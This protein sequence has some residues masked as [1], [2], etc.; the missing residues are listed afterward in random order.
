MQIFP[1]NLGK[2]GSPCQGSWVLL[3]P[4]NAFLLILRKYLMMRLK[5]GFVMREIAGEK[6]ILMRAGNTT[7]MTKAVMLNASSEFLWNS[8]QNM[9]FEVRDVAKLLSGK[10]SVEIELAQADAQRWILSMIDAGLI[11]N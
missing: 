5:T 1:K 11:E 3:L 2:V 4:D 7:D 9:V 6:M 10:Y 8:L